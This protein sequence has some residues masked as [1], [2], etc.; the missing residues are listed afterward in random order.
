MSQTQDY[1]DIDMNLKAG[2]RILYKN[3]KATLITPITPSGLRNGQLWEVKFD[4]WSDHVMRWCNP[5]TI[6]IITGEKTQ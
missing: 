4:K 6:I 5:D 3:E 1:F 2:D